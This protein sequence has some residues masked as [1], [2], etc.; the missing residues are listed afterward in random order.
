MPSNVPARN[1]VREVRDLARCRAA[2]AR[3]AGRAVKEK[4]DDPA[5]R[6][7][8]QTLLTT[9]RVEFEAE[10]VRL[11][12]M[13]IP[14]Q[15]KYICSSICVAG[16]KMASLRREETNSKVM[17]VASLIDIYS[18]KSW[19]HWRNGEKAL[20]LSN[21]LWHAQRGVEN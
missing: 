15:G 2:E 14:P 21:K 20:M 1:G 8:A 7:E 19:R 4:R 5:L 9:Q 11:R 12:E 16:I 13:G 10:P 3:N 18:S 6:H 17:V